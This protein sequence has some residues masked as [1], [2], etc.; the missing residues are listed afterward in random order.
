[1]RTVCDSSFTDTTWTNEASH[2]FEPL[3]KRSV[4]ESIMVKGYSY[5]M[6]SYELLRT[7]SD[8]LN[9]GRGD[10]RRSTKEES[11]IVRVALKSIKSQA[12][13]NSGYH[14]VACDRGR[15][16]LISRDI[17]NSVDSD[18]TVWLYFPH[19][20]AA[21][22]IERTLIVD[23]FIDLLDY[24]QE[25]YIVLGRSFGWAVSFDTFDDMGDRPEFEDYYEFCWYR[26]DL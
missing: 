18:G 3:P 7:L 9:A 13:V 12:F 25:W 4:K 24:L 26:T 20:Q 14:C 21:F 22:E 1:M 6:G 16:D 10:I 23:S 8:F 11:R 15:L 5:H 2:P 19:V 17:L